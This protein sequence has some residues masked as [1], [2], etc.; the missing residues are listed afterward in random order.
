MVNFMLTLRGILTGPIGMPRAVFNSSDRFPG[1]F[2]FSLVSNSFPCVTWVTFKIS[3]P[4]NSRI[5]SEDDLHPH[6]VNVIS[7]EGKFFIGVFVSKGASEMNPFTSTV[8]NK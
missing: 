1:F 2:S 7:F 4:V 8:S 3:Q 6:H 5:A